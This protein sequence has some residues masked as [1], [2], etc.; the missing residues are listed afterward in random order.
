LGESTEKCCGRYIDGRELPPTAE[1]LMRSRYTAYVLEKIDYIVESHN[2]ATRSEVDP[3]GARN[4]SRA[5]EWH[6]LEISATEA[7]GDSDEEGVVEFVARYEMDGRMI[8]HRERATF[9]KINKR[10]FYLDGEMVK[11]KPM[12]REAPKVGRNDP[13]PCGSGKKHKKC[14]GRLSA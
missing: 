1:A 12:V 6:G 2:P 9:Q 14:C 5:A 11:P 10:W 4:W 13:C 7:G 3:D 8:H